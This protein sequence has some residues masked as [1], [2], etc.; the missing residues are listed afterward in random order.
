ML[1][2]IAVHLK[3]MERAGGVGMEHLY[4]TCKIAVLPERYKA[5]K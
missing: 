3:S 2:S 1:F 5:Q 4:S